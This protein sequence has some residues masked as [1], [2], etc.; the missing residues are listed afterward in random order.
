VVRVDAESKTT[1][2]ARYTADVQLPRMLHAY[3]VRSP[4]AHARV[5]RV[6][7][8]RAFQADSGVVAVLSSANLENYFPALPAYDSACS[9]LERDPARQ[10][11]PGDRRLFDP[12]V[13]F[14]GEPVVAIVAET[15]S[16]A[17][18]AAGQVDVEYELL[19]A[20]L[21]PQAAQQAEAPSIHA[22]ARGNV[23]VSL[24][25]RRGD[26]TVALASG[27]VVVERQFVT[28]RQKHVQLE[29][30]C[31]VADVGPDNRVTLYTPTQAPHRVRRTLSR[32]FGL[33]LT[34]VRVLTPAIGGAF[35]KGDGLTA[36]PYAMALALIARRPV[37][38][39]YSSRDDFVGTES[40][41]PMTIDLHASFRPDGTISALRGRAVVDA[42]A[43]L[44]HSAGVAA[45]FLRQLV[46]PYRIEHIDVEAKVVFTNTP[47]SGAFRGYGGAQACFALEHL[48][49]IGARAVGVDPLEARE[50]MRIRAGDAWGH[51]H[52]P[53]VGDAPGECFKRG[54]IAIGWADKRRAAPGDAAASTHRRGVG[55]AWSVWSSGVADRVSALDQSGAV[56]RVNS[57]AS[58][59][60]MS[61]A[62]DL[63][64]GIK[65][66]LAQICADE[67]GVP[68]VNVR[69]SDPDTEMTP[70]DTG[71][72]ASRSLY[73]A[74]KAVQL[75]AA[76]A[77]RKL[78]A[79]AAQVLETS[80]DDLVIAG[81]RIA[82]RGATQRGMELTSVLRRALMDGHE[83]NGY[84]D[85]PRSN[86]PPFAA[87]FA[88]VDVDL[89]TGQVKV[90]RLVAV[91]DVGRAIN[92]TIVEGQIQGAVYQGLGYALTEGLIIDPDNGATV[93]G[94]FM[95]YR[96]L[97]SA[98]GPLVEP[99]IVE[100]PDPS[101]PFGAKGAGE[102]SLVPTAA[103]VANAVLHATGAS[104]THLP[105]TPER[106]LAA[107]QSC[108]RET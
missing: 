107:I 71:A 54:A 84:A 70:Y 2:A 108:A 61:G 101:G 4:H 53:I 13:R 1:G 6:D 21:D 60:V 12:I 85:A 5:V 100:V 62:C 95:D 36:E 69:V 93:N 96:V 9:D 15:E 77:R 103:A 40:R 34:R 91:Q 19:P 73:R 67:F 3:L 58:L 20:L 97:T 86:A 28:S 68:V 35:G 47:V 50:R 74:G 52:Q 76:D 57:D 89:E 75:A 32:L 49:D 66:T 81:G 43:Y 26:P 83:F 64:T 11:L 51:Q 17:R 104:V 98:D 27:D 25:Q 44:T 80:A 99:I 38:L 46:S 33:T 106:V 87:Q 8:A 78:L 7:A 88:E 16:Q 41:H 79:Y 18:W 92:P 82:T 72:H 29:P 56:V 63:G 30:S 55:M 14:A 105:L 48:V 23:A 39:C 31:C 90:L 37:K 102:I 24:S 94:S 45:V 10:T 59:D 65:T 42:G 22:H